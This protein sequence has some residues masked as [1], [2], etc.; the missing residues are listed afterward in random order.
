MNI[1]NQMRKLISILILSIISY[2]F[3]EFSSDEPIERNILKS[4]ENESSKT[5][6][7]VY[8]HVYKKDYILNSEEGIRRY[9]IFK[10]NWN[11]IKQKNNK[12]L[13]Y[14]LGL[15]AFVDWTEEELK[16]LVNNKPG[17]LEASFDNLQADQIESS[18]ANTQNFFDL[19][20]DEDEIKL[21]GNITPSTTQ[22]VK[23]PISWVSKF[24]PVRNQG[25][26][27]SCWT[28]SAAGAM[29]ANY[30]I[31]NNLAVDPTFYL[32]TQQLTDC[33]TNSY[34]CNGGSYVMTFANYARNTGLVRDQIYP[35]R[36]GSTG[37]TG[38]CRNDLV[39]NNSRFRIRTYEGC[40]DCT[41]DQFYSVLSRGPVSTSC[42][43]DSD[44][45]YYTS[46]VFF[47]DSCP[48]TSSNHAIIAVGWGTANTVIGPID[49]TLI[50]NSWGASWGEKGYMR[51]K[52]QPEM[53]KSCY[54]NKRAYRPIF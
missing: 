53:N 49:F 18:S 28:F 37:V 4:F 30:N 42:Y 22:V 33:D 44:W 27:G 45:F 36:S 23:N 51:V 5:L 31:Q 38:T 54:I 20:D 2:A 8:H 35:Y 12:G 25:S 24:P 40:G 15:T 43:A 50:R 46:G 34:G 17:D 9:R 13:T 41:I 11:Y 32:S 26:C 6:F 14:K 29:E 1:L 19:P 16:T 39:Q 52:Y 10:R 21:L 47:V 48:Y 3:S 7:K